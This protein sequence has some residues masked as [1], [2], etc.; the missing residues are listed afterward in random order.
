M[1]RFIDFLTNNRLPRMFLSRE[2][3]IAG[4]LISYGASVPALFR[5]GAL[6]VHKNLARH[7]T[8][9]EQPTKFELVVNLKSANA[10]GIKIPEA[11]LLRADEVIR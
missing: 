5:R 3:V 6:Y 1:R 9:G 10:L 11:V 8:R 2:I 7:Q 4:G